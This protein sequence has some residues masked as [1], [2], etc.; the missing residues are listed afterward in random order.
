MSENRFVGA[1]IAAI[2]AAGL[3]PAAFI[4]A[5]VARAAFDI[6]AMQRTVGLG[7]SDFLL[8]LFAAVTV[9]VLLEPKRMLFERSSC[10]GTA[11]KEIPVPDPR[12][13]RMDSRA[14]TRLRGVLRFKR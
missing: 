3:M 1:G 9:F 5:G 11:Y 2:V 13:L 12:I 4:V 8:L 14:A 6:G 10:R 7:V